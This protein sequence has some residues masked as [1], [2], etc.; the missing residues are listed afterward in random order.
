M[1]IKKEHLVE[2]VGT[3]ALI[4]IGAGTG[5]IGKAGLVGVALA[6]GLVVAVFTWNFGGVSGSHINPAV[7]FGMLV[8]G[9]MNIKDAIGYWISQLLGA[10]LAAAALMMVLGGAESGLGA[11]VLAEGVSPAQGIILEAILTFFLV[12][13][14]LQTTGKGKAGDLAP[15]A[16]G[17]TLI[18]VTLMGGPITGASV[19]PAR[20]FGPA[21]F[22]G[23]LGQL[24]IYIVGPFLGATV[25]AALSKQTD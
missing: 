25:A 4:F 5:A 24:W 21:L 15:L 14:F 12:N 16:I 2:L 7:T 10:A 11:T 1:V 22:T 19:N 18:F 17:L 8:A 6:H 23:N 13:T 3:F 9:K 20:T